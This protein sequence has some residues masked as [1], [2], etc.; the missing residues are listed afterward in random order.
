MPA[1][2]D[3]GPPGPAGS[4]ST[5]QQDVLELIAIGAPLPDV[6]GRLA[7][8]VEALLGEGLVSILVV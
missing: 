5:V 4:F 7:S 2:G 3:P 6:L 1:T 8:G